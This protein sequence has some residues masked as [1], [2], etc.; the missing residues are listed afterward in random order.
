MDSDPED[1]PRRGGGAKIAPAVVRQI[2]RLL[3]IGELSQRQIAKQIG[4]SRGTV[5]AI[6][7]GKRPDYEVL[8]EK[9]DV[10]GLPG[11]KSE[12]VWC[13]PCRA[14]VLMPCV[15]CSARAYQAQRRKTD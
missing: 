12:Y 9:A 7:G 1:H 15:A 8:P 5:N 13:D 14:Y 2:K 11:Q 6:A 3:A 10:P 4:V